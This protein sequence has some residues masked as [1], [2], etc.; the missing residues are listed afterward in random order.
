MKGKKIQFVGFLKVFALLSYEI[1]ENWF[2]KNKTYL[3]VMSISQL[4][5]Y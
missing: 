2:P 1:Q 4:E 3:T 5:S